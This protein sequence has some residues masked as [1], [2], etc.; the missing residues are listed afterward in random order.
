MSDPL[1]GTTMDRRAFLQVGGGAALLCT[2]NGKPMASATPKD[3]ARA[4]A[5]AAGLLVRKPS[6]GLDARRFPAPRPAPGGRVRTYWIEARAV[7]WNLLPTGRDDWMGKRVSGRRTMR[8]FVFQRFSEGFAAPVGPARMPGPLLH[9]EVGDVVEVHFRNAGGHLDQAVTMHT[10]GLRYNPDYDGAYLG[11][12]TRAGGF[13]AP[14]EE[15]TYRWEATPDSVGAWPYHDH[16][17]NH[18]LN[19]R[20]GLFGAIVVRPRGAP[21][22]DREYALFM[23]AMPPALTGRDDQ[24]QCFNGRAFAGNT[25]TLRARVGDDVAIHVFGADDMFHTFHIH[26]HRWRDTAGAPVDN[27]TV[28]PNESHTARFREDNPGRWL[29][30]CH[31]AS[32][33]MAGMAGWYEAV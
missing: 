6:R 1:A 26:G 11:D 5:A 30:H 18:I 8:A 27:P 16:G 2:L 33:M 15:F 29:Y 3:A 7:R 24:L 4:D 31:V 14:G 9:A 17:P 25:P 32:H 28:G 23:H 10:H 13:I 21:V 20:R 22:P 12:H 19:M